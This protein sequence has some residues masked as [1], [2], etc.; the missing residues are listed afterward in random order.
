MAEGGAA[1]RERDREGLQKGAQWKL[2]PVKQGKSQVQQ[3]GR[4]SPCNQQMLGKRQL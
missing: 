3:P 1:A 4:S 2:L